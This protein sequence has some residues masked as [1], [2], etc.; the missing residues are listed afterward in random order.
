MQEIEA[1]GSRDIRV[2]LV[3]Y[4]KCCLYLVMC[5]NVGIIT[6]TLDYFG[7][8]KDLISRRGELLGR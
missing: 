4:L 7:S 6:E 5:V 8:V 3:F 1:T 2:Y